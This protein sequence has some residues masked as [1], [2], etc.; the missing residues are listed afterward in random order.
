MKNAT[1]Q[2]HVLENVGLPPLAYHSGARA[3]DALPVARIYHLDKTIGAAHP[4]VDADPRSQPARRQPFFSRAPRAAPVDPF[5]ER[6]AR[7]S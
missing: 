1:S 6:L 4:R 7:L 5:I 3:P 2:H